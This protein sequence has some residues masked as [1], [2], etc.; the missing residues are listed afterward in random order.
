M[1]IQ[2]A[3]MAPRF[4]ATSNVIDIGNRIPYAV[5]KSLSAKGYTVARSG[6]TYPCAA[7]HGISLWDGL[8]AG[9]IDPQRDGYVGAVYQ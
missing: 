1:G 5:E 4:S 9:G 6:L 3:I 8:L 2:D 7:P